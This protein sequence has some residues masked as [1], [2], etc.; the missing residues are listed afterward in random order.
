[1]SAHQAALMRQY[2]DNAIA[3]SICRHLDAREQD[4]SGLILAAQFKASDKWKHIPI[5]LDCT[6]QPL[7]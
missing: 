4:S 2:T 5:L 7:V 1:M 3:L 6:L